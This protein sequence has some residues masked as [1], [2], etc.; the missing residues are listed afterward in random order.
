V[1]RR[2]IIESDRGTAVA[3]CPRMKIIT[4]ALL[5]LLSI[6]CSADDPAPL[7]DAAP[8]T[9]VPSSPAGAFSVVT[10]LDLAPPPAAELV[11]DALDRA[12]SNPS[13]FILDRMV[14]TLPTA[15]RRRS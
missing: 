2:E 1:R 15:R 7:P 14:A 12:A 3:A 11:V 5:S 13:Q 10:T 6:N 8:L 4:L 9:T